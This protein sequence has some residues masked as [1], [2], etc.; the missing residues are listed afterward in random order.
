M[1]LHLERLNEENSR[2][3]SRASVRKAS[4]PSIRSHA[5][6]GS[7]SMI[8]GRALELGP[9]I[10]RMTKNTLKKEKLDYQVFLLQFKL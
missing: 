3:L 1:E 7:G 10:S 9:A 4:R 6:N 8:G 2:C 5:I